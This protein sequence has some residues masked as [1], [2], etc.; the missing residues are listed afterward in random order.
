MHQLIKEPKELTVLAALS[1]VE[2]TREG[3]VTNPSSRA[4]NLSTDGGQSWPRPGAL[5]PCWA[6]SDAWSPAGKGLP[7]QQRSAVLGHTCS[8][9]LGLH[10]KVQNLQTSWTSLPLASVHL[11][12]RVM[13][14]VKSRNPC[15]SQEQWAFGKNKIKKEYLSPENTPSGGQLPWVSTLLT[16]GG[17][18]GCQEGKSPWEVSRMPPTVYTSTEPSHHPPLCL[19][20]HLAYD[21][22]FP[23]SALPLPRP[24]ISY[25]TSLRLSSF[26]CQKES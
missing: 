9:P 15:L 1:S 10:G 8:L 5:G 26:I 12:S 6:G 19:Q 22:C 4:G 16:S 14:Q 24:W 7:H 11:G 2:D 13:I 21:Q 17:V 25:L 20:Q 23:I 3:H 18:P